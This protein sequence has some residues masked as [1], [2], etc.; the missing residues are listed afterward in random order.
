MSIL[1]KMNIW[2]AD[3]ISNQ[4][5]NRRI[6]RTMKNR[7][8]AKVSQTQAIF[9][10]LKPY[11][12]D[13]PFIRIG[14]DGDG[15]YVMPD[16]LEGLGGSYS[17]GVSDTFTFDLDIA[18]RGVPCYLADA[19]V[20]GVKTN[21]PKICFDKFF[22][23]PK[24][25]EQFISLEDWVKTYTP[26]AT[27]L[28][29]QIDIE[30]AEYEVINATPRS[31]LEQFRIIN[32]EFHN[33]HYVFDSEKHQLVR[34]TLQK[35]NQD[36]YLCHLHANNCAPCGKY[37]GQK[38]PEVFEATYIRKDR[39]KI[40]PGSVTFPHTLDQPNCPKNLDWHMPILWKH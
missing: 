25:Q 9:D 26:D 39:C 34:E 30:G 16:D 38:Y 20:D 22:L 37:R 13:L 12:I 36:F 35:L 23:G 1:K 29:L 32:I 8:P 4:R 28:L 2:L 24:T 10:Q 27:D 40:L 19:S 5:F 33:F 21:H 7:E 15:G 14:G 31:V 18:M 17:P 11:K 6:R 3:S